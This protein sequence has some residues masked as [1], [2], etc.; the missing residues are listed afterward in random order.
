[1][2]QAHEDVN[3]KIFD[4]C[5]HISGSSKVIAIGILD[6][7]SSKRTIERPI[8]EVLLVIHNFQPRLM[9][10]IKNVGDR[11][12]F[13]FAVDQRI[14]ERDINQGFLAEAIAGKLVFPHYTLCGKEYL[15]EKEVALKKR[16]ILELLENFALN[17][18]E[19]AYQ[20]Q[21]KPQ[22][23]MYESL[24]NRIRIFP[25]LS[26]EL[27]HL[28]NNIVSNEPQALN[29]YI[30]AL[31]QLEVEKKIIQSNDYVSISKKF[32][33]ECQNPKIKLLKISK[34][35]PRA[36]LTSL[37][38]VFPQLFNII[39]QYSEIFMETQNIQ[40]KNPDPTLSFIDPQKF[41]FVPTSEG[42]VSLSERTSIK[43][44]AKKMLLNDKNG[45]V[46]IVRFG[47]VLNDVFLIKS[48]SN[49][50]EKKVLVKRFKDWSGFKWFPL[51]LWS[52]GARSFAVS[53]QARLAKECATSE[54]L[55]NEGFNVPKIL[56]VSNGERLVFM[57]Y[58]DG[59][60]LSQAIKRIAIAGKDETYDEELLK[61]SEVGE[62]LAQI[63]TRQIALG[64]TKPENM[65]VTSNG[66]IFLIDF[67]QSTKD[68]DK[69]W[70]I[71]VFLYYSGHY[72]QPLYSYT[73]AE[74]ITKAFINGYLKAGGDGKIIRKAG[75]PK[76]TRVFSV[77]TL[78]STI[79][80][81]S[82]ICSKINQSSK[83]K[84]SV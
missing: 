9:S 73:K 60:N 43:D 30:K 81:I 64:D 22:Y 79:L 82:N 41:V 51:T 84:E 25:L 3:G 32:I 42:M 26:Y 57:E 65:I 44:Y 10:Y 63:H 69:A 19:L 48:L 7:Y 29:S 24:L 5:R 49:G 55:R 38:S 56:H 83:N 53:G 45:N 17:F 66:K 50:I 35:A 54:F 80:A 52:F 11:T 34:I 12:F 18:P 77:F 8:I 36:I 33:L 15:E 14:F 75:A 31:Q 67:E 70:D 47:G 21:I 59:E 20:I 40:W 76:Y 72:L 46:K 27:P 16:L 78:P 37:F 74:V 58:I 39:S 62:I 1:L 28:I 71:A 4:F 13:F 6:D 23:F 2:K 61:I 68:G